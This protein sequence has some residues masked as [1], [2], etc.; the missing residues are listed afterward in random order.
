MAAYIVSGTI[1]SPDPGVY[2]GLYN[3]FYRT[4]RINDN[5]GNRITTRPLGLT[6]FDIDVKIYALAPTVFRSLD[7]QRVFKSECAAMCCWLARQR[8]R[9]FAATRMGPEI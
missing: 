4:E 8:A 5:N 6:T 1:L 7:G 3:Y 9:S 2:G